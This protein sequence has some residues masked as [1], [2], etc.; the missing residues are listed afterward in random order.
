M[1]YVNQFKSY[2]VVWKL[3]CDGIG[4]KF[5]CLFKS[6][7]VVWKLRDRPVL[8]YTYIEFKS[9]YVVWKPYF[10]TYEKISIFV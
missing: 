1:R 2:Y 9:Y 5:Y 3:Y 10:I 4:I 7:Y 6:Y 8:Q